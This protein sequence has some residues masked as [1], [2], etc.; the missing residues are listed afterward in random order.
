MSKQKGRAVP[1]GMGLMAIGVA[2]VAGVPL[3]RMRAGSQDYF[4]EPAEARRIGSALFR[5]AEAVEGELLLAQVL[6]TIIGESGEAGS[7]AEA[8]ELVEAVL[9]ELR[10]H[11]AAAGPSV[12]GSPPGPT[13]DTA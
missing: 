5:A 3:V 1:P 12:D 11:R 9:G 13:V 7:A 10:R 2:D 6:T 4:F 8:G